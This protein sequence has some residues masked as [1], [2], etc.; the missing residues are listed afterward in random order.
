MGGLPKAH[1]GDGVPFESDGYTVYT[2]GSATEDKPVGYGAIV[3]KENNYHHN[4][5]GSIGFNASVY[6]GEV[7]AVDRAAEHL[8][9]LDI[10]A[11]TPITFFIDSQATILS[12]TGPCCASLTAQRCREKLL[13]LNTHDLVTLNWV[14]AHA[15]HYWNEEADNLAKGGSYSSVHQAVPRS[16]KNIY[17]ELKTEYREKWWKLWSQDKTCRQTRLMLPKPNPLYTKIMLQMSRVNLSLL[18]QFITGHNYLRYHKSNSGQFNAGPKC[19]L[20]DYAIMRRKHRKRRRRMVKQ[21]FLGQ[22]RK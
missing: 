6:Q 22:M 2:D 16:L 8:L 5:N 20:C 14:K 7:Y 1:L 10:P 13:A 21:L 15:G 19:R 11:D 9:S 18:V 3:L 17:V 4:L 12:L